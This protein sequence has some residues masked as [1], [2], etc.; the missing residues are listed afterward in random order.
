MTLSYRTKSVV[1]D[2]TNYVKIKCI[3][4][5]VPVFHNYPRDILGLMFCVTW[6]ASIVC[7][8]TKTSVET[9]KYKFERKQEI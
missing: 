5:V 6:Y 9:D 2:H 8:S 7:Y 4:P 3:P 1:I